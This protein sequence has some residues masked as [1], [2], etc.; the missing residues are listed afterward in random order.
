MLATLVAALAALVLALAAAPAHA[1]CGGVQTVGAKRNVAPGLAPLAIGDSTMLLALDQLA[2][3]GF[4]VNAHGCRQFPEGLALL[5]QRRHRH[6]L[7]HMVLIAL[8]AD[9]SI[10]AGQVRQAL[11]LL[12]RGRVLV[13]VVPRELGGG[14]SS[15]AT[16]V[17]DA[18]RRYPDRVYVLDWVRYSAG[19][20]GWFQPDH[21]HLTTGGAGV[22]T[23]YLSR[24]LFLAAP[25]VEAIELAGPPPRLPR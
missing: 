10:T 16:V 4:D 23:R 21:L 12:G 13:L 2:A 18:G 8:G 3:R 17:R 9:A 22:F 19:H 11:R 1:G 25:R 20:E 7:P 14:T 6:R 15:D 24:S 5:A